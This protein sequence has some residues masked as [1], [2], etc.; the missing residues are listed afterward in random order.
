MKVLLDVVVAFSRRRGNGRAHSGWDYFGREFVHSTALDLVRVTGGT[1]AADWTTAVVTNVWSAIF[2][3]VMGTTAASTSVRIGTSA[4]FGIIDGIPINTA[5]DST[6]DTRASTKQCSIYVDT[7]I[8]VA[9]IVGGGCRAR[10]RA[11][12]RQSAKGGA[13]SGVRSSKGAQARVTGPAPG[14]RAVQRRDAGQ[15]VGA[16]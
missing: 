9:G 3:R 1:A 5:L 11:Q 16:G 10:A 15:V 4:A 8:V 13:R 6:V 14:A 7:I 12:C 2:G